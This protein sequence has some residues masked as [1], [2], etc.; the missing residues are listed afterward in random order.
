MPTTVEQARREV[1]DAIMV[2]TSWSEPDQRIK[3]FYV[4][5]MRYQLLLQAKMEKTGEPLLVFSGCNVK[6]LNRY[7]LYVIYNDG[8]HFEVY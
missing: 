4:D 7:P 8:N 6:V 2:W 3:A 1:L 5:A